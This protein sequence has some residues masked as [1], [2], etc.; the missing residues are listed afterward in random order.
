MTHQITIIVNV[1]HPRTICIV[2][3]GTCKTPISANV[4]RCALDRTLT[5]TKEKLSTM[6]F[7]SVS[8]NKA[9]AMNS[10]NIRIRI[11]VN[12]SNSAQA[13]NAVHLKLPTTHLVHAYQTVL[14]DHAKQ[15]SVSIMNHAVVSQDV[16]P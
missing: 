13:Y 16:L 9:G 5:V 14:K 6:T 11:P 7:V 3:L 4:L 10:E 12:A 15:R 1:S 2:T 8:V